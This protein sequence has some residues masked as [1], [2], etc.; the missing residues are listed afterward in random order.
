MV[1]FLDFSKAFD[2]VSHKLLNIKLKSYGFTGKLFSWLDNFLHHRKQ[3]VVIGQ[4]ES[5]W[6][7]VLGGV[8]QCSVLGPLLFLIFINDLPEIVSQFCKL[9]YSKLI[10]VIRNTSD[11]M[12]IQE[13]IDKI[14]E[15]SKRWRMDFNESKC[16]D[17]YRQLEV[18]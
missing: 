18:W 10:S 9:L 16:K 5:D 15:W 14:F 2:R 8:P 3:R 12:I 17:V 6:V 4:Y 13:D 11:Q 7:D 1:V